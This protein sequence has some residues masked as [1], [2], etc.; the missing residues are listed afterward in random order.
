MRPYVETMG[1]VLEFARQH[2]I[3]SLLRELAPRANYVGT[4]LFDLRYAS[5]AADGCALPFD[6]ASF[7]LILSFHVLEHIPDDIAAMREMRRVLKPGG[8]LLVQVPRREGVPTEEDLD[9]S[10]EEKTRRFG[11]SD[12]VR[13]YGDDL[14]A[15]FVSAG[16]RTSFFR[17]D[18]FLSVADLERF[19]VPAH[20]PLWICRRSESVGNVLSSDAT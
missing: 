3:Q 18:S 4:D 6:D 5:V 15:R 17:A 12:H 14:E 1:A 10:P 7:D 11:Q 8:L 13:Y 20:N 2:Q 9:A 19:N 16:L